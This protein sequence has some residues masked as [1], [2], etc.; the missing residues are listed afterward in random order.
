MASEDD[1]GRKWKESGLTDCKSAPEFLLRLEI[2]KLD[3]GEEDFDYLSDKASDD[4]EFC[5]VMHGLVEDTPTFDEALSKL[6][7][8]IDYYMA[9]TGGKTPDPLDFGRVKIIDR[10]E[11]GVIGRRS[12]PS[13]YE[14]RR[15][16]LACAEKANKIFNGG[17]VHARRFIEKAARP[18]GSGR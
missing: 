14:F 10:Y 9:M 6:V 4:V 2:A 11:S 7:F 1:L 3:V 8:Y 5:H 17:L 16:V 18:G 13:A 15:F 12:G